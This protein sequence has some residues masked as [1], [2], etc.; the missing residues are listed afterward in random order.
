MPLINCKVE[1]SL[2]WIERC[3][4][5]VANTV[6]FKITDA[7]LYEPIVTLSS[8]D[9]VKLS[10]LLSRGFKIPIYWNEY[11]V[12]PNK[13]VEIAANNEK[14]KKKKKKYIRELLDS[15]WQGVKRLFVL[16]Y[17]NKEGNNQ[18]SIDSNKTYSKN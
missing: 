10:K 1:I 11:K 2:K 16:T 15:S 6:A 5:T 18:V 13:I 8:E 17:N 9:N 14:K 4:L 7:K 3:L 12:I